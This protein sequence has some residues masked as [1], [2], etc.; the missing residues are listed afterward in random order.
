MRKH[1]RPPPAIGAPKDMDDHTPQRKCRKCGT[2]YPLTDD[3]FPKADETHWRRICLFCFRDVNHVRYL[4]NKS[5]HQIKSKRY[6]EEHKEKLLIRNAIYRKNH[7]N[8]MR[9]YNEKW[10]NNH[11]DVIREKARIRDKKHPEER[12]IIWERRRARK[13][14]LPDTFTLQEWNYALEYFNGCCAVCQRPPGLWHTLAQDHWI[15]ID[16][17]GEDNP[18]TVAGNIIPLCHG[19]DGCNNK[20][21]NQMPHDWLYNIYGYKKA[22]I[23]ERRIDE[24]FRHLIS[25]RDDNAR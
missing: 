9:S 4:K 1:P 3:Y 18:G 22:R 13:L 7:K 21:A 10:R 8:E 20:K 5:K 16:Y 17:K 14:G 11:R 25:K 2:E 6:Y 23:I 19:S 12:H 15:P 24:Y